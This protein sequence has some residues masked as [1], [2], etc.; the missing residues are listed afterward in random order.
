M[1]LHSSMLCEVYLGRCKPTSPHPSRN[2][3]KAQSH[4]ST[5]VD[6]VIQQF[7]GII[8]RNVGDPKATASP[9]VNNCFMENCVVQSCFQLTIY[10]HIDASSSQDHLL[11]KEGDKVTA[12]IPGQ[13]SCNLPFVAKDYPYFYCYITSCPVLL[14]LVDCHSYR[15]V[16]ISNQR[17]RLNDHI[18]RRVLK[19]SRLERWHSTKEHLSALQ[20]DLNLVPS[21]TLGG[22]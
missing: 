21:I 10:F 16:E 6:W 17:G 2:P 9:H 14:Y 19:K 7:T 4:H 8:Y 3:T 1:V 5:T 18:I 12:R 20:E 22:S 15:E 13:R 11:L